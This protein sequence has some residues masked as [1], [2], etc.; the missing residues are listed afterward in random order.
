MATIGLAS[1]VTAVEINENISINGFIDGSYANSDF[2]DA[3]TPANNNDVSNSGIDEVELNFLV[4]AGNVSGELHID[5]EDLDNDTDIDIEQVHFTYS[6]ENGASITVGRAGSLLGFERE[7]P[8]GLYTFSRAYNDNTYDRGNVDAGNVFEGVRIS[9]AADSFSAA[10]SLGNDIGSVE[11]NNAQED[12]Y[13]YELAITYTGLENLSVTA[14]VATR[15]TVDDKNPVLIRADSDMYTVN[16][17][18]TLEKLLLGG[19]YISIETDGAQDTSAYMLI[20][21]YDITDALGAALRYS[22]WESTATAGQVNDK[23]T[24]AA[25]YAITSS[26]GAIVEFSTEEISGGADAGDETDTFAIELTYT[27]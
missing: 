13:D 17:A 15:N 22:E 7:D 16:A 23:V 4:N 5:T 21:D 18:Y 20:A 6:F 11:E 2:T 24:F 1:S 3:D 10:L 27:F 25:N 9:Y 26:L 8:A 14:G 12:D 19:E